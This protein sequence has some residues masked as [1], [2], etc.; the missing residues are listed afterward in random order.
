MIRKRDDEMTL[1]E[2]RHASRIGYSSKVSIVETLLD[3]HWCQEE[4]LIFACETLQNSELDI[5]IAF[6]QLPFLL[7]LPEKWIKINSEFGNPYIYFRTVGTSYNTIKVGEQFRVVSRS[8]YSDTEKFANA[9]LPNDFY[10]L[11]TQTQAIVSFQLWGKRLSHYDQYSKYQAML[12]DPTTFERE[13]IYPAKG[14]VSRRPLTAQTYEIEVADVLYKQT[15]RILRNFIPI[16]AVS[17][18]DPFAR[19]TENLANYFIMLKPGRV[20]VRGPGKSTIAQFARPYE[21][22]NYSHNIGILKKRVESG[23]PPS[24]YEQYLL[25][26]A[27]QAELGACNL[28]IVQTVMILD[29]FANEILNDRLLRQIR[30]SFDHLPKLPELV[31][32]RMWESKTDKRIRP[33]TLGKFT[34]YFPAIGLELPSELTGALHEVITLRNKIVHHIQAKP[35]ESE[36]AKKAVKLGLSI[37]QHCMS[38]LLEKNK[39]SGSDGI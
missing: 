3:A 16:Y 13:K 1:D 6:F 31:I 24:I 28:A 35:I 11:L 20:V 25:E 26:A 38:L 32:D 30:K 7:R 5:A 8:K 21:F 9:V 18:G 23:R 27:R 36:V 4:D 2:I 19:P 29:L 17:C 22:P 12:Q 15:R 10:G 39:T 34:E 14:V 33:T 37:I